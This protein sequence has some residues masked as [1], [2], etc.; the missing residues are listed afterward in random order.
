M[1]D[2]QRHWTDRRCPASRVIYLTVI[3]SF[4]P[5][6]SNCHIS[7]AGRTNSN[8]SYE[9]AGRKSSSCGPANLRVFP[10]REPLFTRKLDILEVI[11]GRT[12]RFDC[13]VSGS[14]APRVTWM[15]FEND[16]IRILQEG[17]RHSL[18]ISH[19]S[20]D[21]E[22]FYTAIAENIHG[23]AECTAELYMEGGGSEVQSGGPAVSDHLLVPQRQT[24]REQR[25]T[26]NDSV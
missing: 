1:N 6:H 26:E 13:K 8:L 15:H 5:A 22:G 17:G 21:T 14:P 7:L 19:V 9:D 24:H 23:K 11:E 20:G 12:A 10:S 3:G 4:T 25:G 16:N 18:V 2:R